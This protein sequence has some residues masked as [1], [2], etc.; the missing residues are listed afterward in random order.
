M[1]G[2]GVWGH[3]GSVGRCDR[4]NIDRTFSPLLFFMYDPGASPQAGIGRTVGALPV[5]PVLP[6]GMDWVS[7]GETM[8][9]REGGVTQT[10]GE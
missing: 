7:Y 2:F 3:C 10:I 6:H 8:S 9:C 4:C 1:T 5:L